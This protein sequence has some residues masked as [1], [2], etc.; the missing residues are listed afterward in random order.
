MLVRTLQAKN[1]QRRYEFLSEDHPRHHIFARLR[2]AY[3]LVLCTVAGNV[4]PQEAAV[5]NPSSAYAARDF[6]GRFELLAG[7]TSDDVLGDPARAREAFLEECRRKRAYMLQ[8][9][10]ERKQMLSLADEAR[11]LNFTDFVVQKTLT[12]EMLKLA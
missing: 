8:Q 3:R 9:D 4:A 5:A 2:N 12:L 10:E 7:E 11:M 1:Q 6:Q